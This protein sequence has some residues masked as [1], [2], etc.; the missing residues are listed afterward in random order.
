MGKIGDLRAVEPLIGLLGDMEIRFDVVSALGKLQDARA[1]E[2]L[3]DL[4][5]DP[6]AEFREEV[7]LALEIIGEAG[8]DKLPDLEED[9][10]FQEG[11][12]R[13]VVATSRNPQLRSAAKKRWGLKCFCCGFDF[14]Q[15]YGPEAKGLAI[16]HH[17]HPF[18]NAKGGPRKA[19]VEDVRVVCANCH[20]V[21]HKKDPPRD[22]EE[23]R[24]M[25]KKT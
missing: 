4:L 9:E 10:T 15:F 12:K 2:P 13:M 23:I 25:V 22:V 7:I 16:V 6:D 24:R 17:L 14:G 21:I 8:E 3:K 1:E 20:Y 18:N 11:G 5:D 19:T